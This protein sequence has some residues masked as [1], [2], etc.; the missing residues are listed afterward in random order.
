MVQLTHLKGGDFYMGMMIFIS[1]LITGLLLAKICIMF[2]DIEYTESEQASIFVVLVAFW[3]VAFVLML[4]VLL[5]ECLIGDNN[6][7]GNG[8]NG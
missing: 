4:I 1:Y 6:D 5:E 8:M 7:E 2:T 3:P